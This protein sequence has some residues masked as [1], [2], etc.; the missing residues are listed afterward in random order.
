MKTVQNLS[1]VVLLNPSQNIKTLA[2]TKKAA[3]HPPR[4][5]SVDLSQQGT[6]MAVRRRPCNKGRLT[7]LLGRPDS[8]PRKVSADFD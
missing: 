3:N 2:Q 5:N 1:W 8:F 6:E 7:S 4:T